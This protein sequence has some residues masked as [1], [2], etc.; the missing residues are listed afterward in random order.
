MS[1]M[2]KLNKSNAFLSYTHLYYF[3]YICTVHFLSV[4]RWFVPNQFS[5]IL[6]SFPSLPSSSN[7]YISIVPYQM[8]SYSLWK[9]EK[10]YKYKYNCCLER[11]SEIRTALSVGVKNMLTTSPCRDTKGNHKKITFLPYFC[12]PPPVLCANSDMSTVLT[13]RQVWPMSTYLL[14]IKTATFGV[15]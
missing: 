15:K 11:I 13:S 4:H 9:I 12:L 6:I 14:L 7:I 5:I 1:G 3:F 8:L 10:F 2:P